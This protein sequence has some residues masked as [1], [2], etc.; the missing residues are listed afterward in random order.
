M[1]GIVYGLRVLLMFHL[2]CLGWLLFRADGFGT[3]PAMLQRIVTDPIP[4]SGV[5]PQVVL[6]L[7]YCGP[8]F[9]LEVGLEGEERVDRLTASAPY[10]LVIAYAYV[11]ILMLVFHASQASE[12][13]Y[14]QF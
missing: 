12:F 14:F 10:R 13:I 2:T 8:L 7:F 4:T 9:L 11:L 1:Q 3:A 6:M 5:I